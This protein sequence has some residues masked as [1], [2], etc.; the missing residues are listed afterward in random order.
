VTKSFKLVVVFV[1][2]GFFLT[3]SNVLNAMNHVHPAKTTTNALPVN[4]PFTA[5]QTTPANHSTKFKTAFKPTT[6]AAK[7]ATPVSIPHNTNVIH[8]SPHV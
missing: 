8:V 4:Q 6:T 3:T 7:N 5:P 2:R 1:K